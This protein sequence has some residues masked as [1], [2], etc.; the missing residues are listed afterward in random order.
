MPA[1]RP[2]STVGPG[3]QFETV[4]E[5][6]G[7]EDEEDGGPPEESGDDDEFINADTTI[8]YLPTPVDRSELIDKLPWQHDMFLQQEAEEGEP[9]GQILVDGDWFNL[10]DVFPTARSE[11]ASTMPRGFIKG[12]HCHAWRYRGSCT[13]KENCTFIHVVAEKGRFAAPRRPP[14]TGMKRPREVFRP[15]AP[16]RPLPIGWG[17]GRGPGGTADR[18]PIRDIGPAPGVVEQPGARLAPIPHGINEGIRSRLLGR[19]VTRDEM[20]SDESETDESTTTA[21]QGESSDGSQASEGESTDSG[22]R[23]KP[24]RRTAVSGSAPR[25]LQSQV[26]PLPVQRRKAAPAAPAKVKE[27]PREEGGKKKAKR[28]SDGSHRAPTKA[29]AGAGRD[30]RAMLAEKLRV[31]KRKLEGAMDT[32]K[33][34]HAAAEVTRQRKAKQ[35]GPQI[36]EEPHSDSSHEKDRH[37]IPSKSEKSKSKRSYMNKLQEVS[38][39]TGKPRTSLEYDPER[40]QPVYRS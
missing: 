10:Y 13:K 17:I 18:Y 15:P 25:R 12:L 19:G 21:S 9:K 26:A 22:A 23:H 24:R 31:E 37:R 2:H 20:E 30:T 36:K 8:E 3:R 33:K 29:K 39:A 6:E 38:R 40:P 32:R 28:P 5:D 4:S 14:T 7:E 34:E 16:A 11:M 27:E 35:K 1:Q